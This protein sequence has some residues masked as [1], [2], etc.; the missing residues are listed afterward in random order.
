MSCRTSGVYII[1][2]GSAATIYRICVSKYIALRKQYI[3]RIFGPLFEGAGGQS[4]AP[5]R[6]SLLWGEEEQGSLADFATTRLEYSLRLAYARHLPR[7]GRHFAEACGHAS[8]R[9]IHP[10]AVGEGLAPPGKISILFGIKYGE[11]DVLPNSPY[12]FV[13]FR[14]L[15]PGRASP[16]P[17]AGMGRLDVVIEPYGRMRGDGRS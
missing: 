17:T 7:R 14:F 9:K 4:G 8:L 6:A 3:A 1:S 10:Y 11:F 15:P 13:D 12:I 5:T 16:A 2:H